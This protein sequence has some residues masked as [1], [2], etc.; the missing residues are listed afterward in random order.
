MFVIMSIVIGLHY[1]VTM[2]RINEV[3]TTFNNGEKLYVKIE[4]LEN[5]SQSLVIEKSNDWVLENHMLSSKTIV[6][7]FYCKM[8]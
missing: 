5:V 1:F 6:E 8:Y 3:E 4:L 7:I 2:S